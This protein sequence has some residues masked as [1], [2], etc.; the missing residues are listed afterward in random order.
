MKIRPA[1]ILLLLALWVGPCL[2]AGCATAASCPPDDHAWLA[3]LSF[4]Q[5]DRIDEGWA[6][7][8]DEEMDEHPLPVACLATNTTEGAIF[9]HGHRDR[10]AEERTYAQICAW[11]SKLPS[12]PPAPA[13]DCG[14]RAP[15]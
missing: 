3:A 12:V 7:M 14:C 9:V 1:T 6:V 2:L 5:V 4:A 11:L 15:P 8:V 13:P 10:A